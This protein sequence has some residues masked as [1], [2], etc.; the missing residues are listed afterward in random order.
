MREEVQK[1]GSK[2]A[3]L[4][5]HCTTLEG[6]AERWQGLWREAATSNA[7]LSQRL[8]ALQDGQVKN[9]SSSSCPSSVHRTAATVSN[10]FSVQKHAAR[11]AGEG[12]QFVLLLAAWFS[13]MGSAAVSGACVCRRVHAG[14]VVLPLQHAVGGL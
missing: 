2:V 8:A 7:Q 13:C 6:E 1:M 3:A 14:I 10:H 5:T 9:V 11:Q 12:K 4:Q